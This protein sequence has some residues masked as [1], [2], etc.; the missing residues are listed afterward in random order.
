VHYKTVVP[1][2][3]PRYDPARM[4]TT[5]VISVGG[6]IV[7]PDGVDV[8]FLSSFVASLRLRLERHPDTRLALVV[9]GGSTARSYQQA[10]R[11]IDPQA[12]SA[13]LDEIGIA[14]TR[15]NAQVVRTAFGSLCEDPVFTDP[16][17]VRSITGRVLVGGGWKPGF[18]TDNV[19][20]RLAEALGAATVIN[21]SN[22]R[23]IYTADPKLDPSAT[24]LETI[25]W[26][27]LLRIVGD[28]W[29]PGK[30]TPFD[31]VATRRAAELG[32]TV[33][34]ADGRDLPNLEALLDGRPFVGTTIRP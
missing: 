14:A 26:D 15:V 30:N 34:A 21:L 10:A 23:Q 25:S 5:T 27:E 3:D 16:T 11:E 33:I 6:S 28:E 22:I 7:V 9:G 32:M 17:T 24:A 4:A 18:S 13:S 20:V 19:T 8:E 29:V 31:P 2:V 12:D 1:K